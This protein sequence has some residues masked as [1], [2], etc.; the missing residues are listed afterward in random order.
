[1][2]KISDGRG[3][4]NRFKYIRLLCIFF[5]ILAVSITQISWSNPTGNIQWHKQSGTSAVS[6]SRKNGDALG[7]RQRLIQIDQRSLT[8]ETEISHLTSGCALT[9]KWELPQTGEVPKHFSSHQMTTPHQGVRQLAKSISTK[10]WP[11]LEQQTSIVS[12]TSSLPQEVTLGEVEWY[13]CGWSTL[14]ED[15]NKATAPK[16]RPTL[17]NGAKSTPARRMGA[18]L[19]PKLLKENWF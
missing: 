2:R 1:M 12:F 6:L 19:R 13:G 16:K 7:I 17:P 3:Y 14:R 4:K 11:N 8:I 9:L 18:L 5:S 10:R 15:S